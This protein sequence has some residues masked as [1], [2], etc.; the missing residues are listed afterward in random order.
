MADEKKGMTFG[1]IN[2]AVNFIVFILLLN[3]NFY[4]RQQNTSQNMGGNYSSSN[5]TKVGVSIWT[6]MPFLGVL[7]LMIILAGITI[8]IF[9]IVKGAKEDEI[10]KGFKIFVISITALSFVI[11]LFIFLLIF[12]NSKSSTS[13]MPG[14]W[15]S[16]SDN[17]GLNVA[18]VFYLIL[19][20]LVNIS[21]CFSCS[22]F[23]ESGSYKKYGKN[24]YYK[25]SSTISTTSSSFFEGQEVVAKTEIYSAN[26]K[27]GEHL[28]VTRK[29]PNSAFIYCKNKNGEEVRILL[30]YLEP[31]V[32]TK[33]STTT[34][35]KNNEVAPS[36]S[37][38]SV[39]SAIKK[40]K[41]KQLDYLLESK[42][43]SEEEYNSEKEKIIN[44]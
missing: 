3:P 41:I 6:E 34:E 29:I 5:G 19:S 12:I 28:I 30:S 10:S 23:E 42:L 37:E 16:H 27:A 39:E 35:Q 17:L 4:Y 33:A 13:G 2:A 32:K 24:Y 21:A 38:E 22:F 44:G 18:G 31:D 43:I 25:S 40:E 11:N 14:L 15:T 9:I 7:A 36:N 1:I 20:V 8:A 26:V